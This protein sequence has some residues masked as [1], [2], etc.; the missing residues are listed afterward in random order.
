MPPRTS[1]RAA[2]AGAVAALAPALAKGRAPAAGPAFAYPIHEPGRAPGDGFFVEIGYA[3]ENLADFPGWWHTGENWHRLAGDTA[4]AEV[5]AAAAGEVVFAGYDYPGPVVI[6][7]H[8]ADLFSVYGHLD[9]ALDVAVGDRLARGQRIGA[10]LPQAAN[11]AHLH[12]E[13][14]TFLTNDRVNGAAPEWGVNCGVQCPPGPGYWPMAASEHPSDLGWRNPTHAI[15]RRAWPGG[16][17]AGA[18]AVVAVG[19]AGIIAL[20]SVP[21]GQPGAE[22]IGEMAL[23]PGARLPLRGIAAGEEADR[24][25]GA[26]ATRL[27]YRIGLPQ[28]DAA[29]L[30]ATAPSFDFVGADGRPAAVRFVLLPAVD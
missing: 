10:V 17:P 15:A 7:R 3:C 11:N 20:W 28:G 14:R 4:G 12:F 25:L 5:V 29:W 18:E 13:L 21:P 22:P 8:A 1:R 24:G 2:I 19:A 9:Y 16:V 26:D 23:A 27:W 6:V 30:Q